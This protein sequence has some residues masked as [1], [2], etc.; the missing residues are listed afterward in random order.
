[1][2]STFSLSLGQQVV[3]GQVTTGRFDGQTPTLVCGTPDGKVLLHSPHERSGGANKIQG[4][5]VLNFNRKITALSAGPLATTSPSPDV[6]FVGTQSNLLAYD[7]ERNAD[8]FFRDVQDGV[9]ALAL[10]R[11]STSSSPLIV[12]GGNC[13]ILGFDAT[14][15]E[16]LWTVTG[17]NVSSMA[18]C[19]VDNDGELELLVGSD[20]FEIRAFRGEELLSETIETDRVTFLA[21]MQLQQ[22]QGKASSSSQQSFAYGLANGTIG[23][24]NGAKTRMW[25]V[26][27]KH[28]VTALE[29][30]DV[31]GD[32]VAEV[33]S[34][35]SNGNFTVR[36]AQNGEV[37]FKEMSS[38][39]AISGIVKSDYRMDGKEEIIVCSESGEVRGYLPADAELI[40]M[41]EDGVL[42]ANTEDQKEIAKLQAEKQALLAEL[43]LLER[44]GE[45]TSSS[46][47]SSSSFSSSSLNAQNANLTYH[48]E[49][50]AQEGFVSLRVE[51]STDVQ[52]ANL[53]AIDQEGA[54][55]DGSEVLVMSPAS[56]SRSAVL[57]FRPSKNQGGKLRIQTHISSRTTSGYGGGSALQLFVHEN[58]VQVPKF[59]AFK[60]VSS[61]SENW[62]DPT[63]KVSLRINES[64]PRVA[65]WIRSSFLTPASGF[66]SSNDS[67]KVRFRSV[68]K[69]NSSGS[70]DAADQQDLQTLCIVASVPS[71]KKGLLQL[72]VLCD[73][74][75]LAADLVQDLAKFFK[76]AEL[77][78]EADFPAEI[79]RFEE[80]RV[81]WLQTCYW[82]P[83]AAHPLTLNPHPDTHTTGF[84]KRRRLERCSQP[85]LRGHGR[86]PAARQGPRG[87]RGGLAP[88]QR[89]G[90]N[91]SRVHRFARAQQS[92]RRRLQHSCHQPRGALG[93]A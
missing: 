2:Q 68:F 13:S 67:L 38:T 57:P 9:N 75:E 93:G 16:V 29:A 74:M 86:R 55:L 73:S 23:A 53:I 42:K 31:D 54:I 72:R 62:S 61:S 85:S 34:G 7:V 45:S 83:T 47:S 24:Y 41:T 14:G 1:M 66:K 6:L 35:W 80:V 12:A 88:A 77:D 25:R 69:R 43:R 50:N 28:K 59:A 65:D 58:V 36:R 32:G 22:T 44:R 8:L 17:D 39:S 30:F 81:L 40:A 84:E 60:M 20:D 79:A 91:A 49:P 87:A 56:L 10:R 15:K 48:L 27:A 26:K 51:A 76:I 63:S 19:D 18:F 37:L 21:N 5:R 11:L 46:S 78:A 71:E 64:V 90:R 82:F 89:H 70:S 92:T 52:I 3:Q 4:L 33:V